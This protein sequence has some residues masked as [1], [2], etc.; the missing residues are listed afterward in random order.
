MGKLPR[1]RRLWPSPR[2]AADRG[3]PCV[4]IVGMLGERHE[5]LIET[6]VFHSCTSL[7]EHVPI[8]E[9]MGNPG[10]SIQ[11]VAERVSDTFSQ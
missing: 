2:A 10:A 1:A 6:G 9:A 8:E 7:L 5:S 11:F 4:A 3:V